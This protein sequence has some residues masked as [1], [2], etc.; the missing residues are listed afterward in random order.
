[1]QKQKNFSDFSAAPLCYDG[2]TKV[3]TT[4]HNQTCI[5]GAWQIT[6]ACN[7][8]CAEVSV[9]I[10]NYRLLPSSIINERHSKVD[11]LGRLISCIIKT[12]PMLSFFKD[13]TKVIHTDGSCC[14]CEQI[15][16]IHF[17]IYNLNPSL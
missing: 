9:R 11:L 5:E 12:I 6:D 10:A 7:K 14:S 17:V 3:M 1:M 4:C 8:L 2:D 16:K 15:S 13:E